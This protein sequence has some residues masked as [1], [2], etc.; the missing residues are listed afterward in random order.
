MM[1][2]NR[3][4]SKKCVKKFMQLRQEK[5]G[6]IFDISERGAKNIYFW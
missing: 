2:F 4:K 3:N 6:N 5:H 1:E